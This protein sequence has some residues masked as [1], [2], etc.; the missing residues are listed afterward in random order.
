MYDSV[1]LR[2]LSV[3]SNG[4]IQA[5]NGVT[6]TPVTTVG[7]P[8]NTGPIAFDSSRSRI[9]MSTSASTETWEWDGLTWLRFEGSGPL[10][11]GSVV[12]DAAR[13]R[14][15]RFAPAGSK[16]PGQ[17][18]S[19]DGAAW[20][21]A[22]SS[23][24]LSGVYP[25]VYDS[26]R[27]R[28]ILFGPTSAGNREY[29]EWNGIAWT[30]GPDAPIG[31]N[32]FSLMFDV[33]RATLVVHTGSFFSPPV[34]PSTWECDT[35]TGAWVRR[36]LGG[37]GPAFLFY[38]PLR[39]V[40]MLGG[41]LGSPSWIWNGNASILPIVITAVQPSAQ[42]VYPGQSVECSVQVQTNG[43][44]SYQW[45][46][47][48]VA[49]TNT[50]NISGATTALLRIDPVTLADRGQYRVDI[51]NGC[52]SQSGGFSLYVVG[53]PCYPNCDGST[54]LPLLVA[55]DFMCFI[56]SFA[57]GEA[58]ANCDQSTGNPQL[59]ASDFQCF[60]DHFAGGCR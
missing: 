41:S 28:V 4:S 45:F 44:V 33:G 25:M 43:S 34:W 5:W 26:V 9:V 32:P 53:T 21:L 59:T 47:D 48:N 57:N 37:P 19:W 6:W 20:T 16:Q 15:V 17:T 27:Q 51:A 10:S 3:A 31:T 56:N 39:G 50:G 29:W 14:V 7:A 35:A 18:W 24:P 36:S 2:V 52:D 40:G 42:Q 23:G 46:H 12:Y 38:D 8:W 60:I 13:Q 1:Q 30:R 58:Y 54:V 55:N 11:A 49:L 22:S